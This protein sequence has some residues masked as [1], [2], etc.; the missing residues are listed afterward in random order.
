MGVVQLRRLETTGFTSG[1]AHQESALEPFILERPA[2]APAPR[3]S[4]AAEAFRLPTGCV[5]GSYGW[6]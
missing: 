2:F 1:N 3:T 5:D 4:V 6:C